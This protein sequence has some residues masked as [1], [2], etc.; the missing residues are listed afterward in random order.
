MQT[1]EHILQT[2]QTQINSNNHCIGVAAG[3]GMTARCT[4]HGGADFILALSAGKFRQIG[5]GSFASLLCYSNSNQVVMDFGTRELLPALPG[6]PILFGLN[7]TDPTIDLYEYLKLI[8]SKGFSGINNFPTIG[9]IDGKFRL[10]LEQEGVNFSREVEAIR[11]ASFLGLF[12]VAF[13]FDEQQ[14]K[15]MIEAGADVICVHLGL[16]VG[17]NIG[18]RKT[19]SLELARIRM[20]QIMNYCERLKPG[21]LKMIYGGPI[22][23]PEDIQLFYSSPL[24][25][26]YIGGSAFERIPVEKAL[27][28]TVQAFRNFGGTKSGR[29]AAG[30][31]TLSKPVIDDIDCIRRYIE[32]HYN[33]NF[34]LSDLAKLLHRSPSYLSVRFKKETGYPFSEYLVRFR[35]GKAA[36]MLQKSNRS[37]VYISGAVGYRDYAHFS[38]IF[39]K[40]YGMPP[41]A[42]RDQRNEQGESGC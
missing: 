6:T 36:E 19:L 32:E 26:G 8:Q 11:I 31:S 2:L 17:G 39:K 22:G 16:T 10:A 30:F 12:T 41:S 33:E 15:A 7:A 35:L 28:E 1:K 42:F 4:V 13:V 38:K 5:L 40:Y 18:A 34:L 37:L 23:K 29:T 3:C 9:L 14:A 27:T 21:I 20:E 25:K 24:C